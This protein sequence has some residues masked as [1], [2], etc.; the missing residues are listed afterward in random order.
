MKR[1]LF[2]AFI[3]FVFCSTACFNPLHNNDT[4]NDQTTSISDD[5]MLRLMVIEPQN[6]KKDFYKICKHMSQCTA[7]LI[8]KNQK[9]QIPPSL[10]NQ[11][12]ET[13]PILKFK[14][15]DTEQSFYI[16]VVNDNYTTQRGMMMRRAFADK[17]G[18]LF[19]FPE[20]YRHA[21]WMHNTYI[22]LDMVFIRSDGT[23]ANTHKNAEPLN[24]GP[25]YASIG[26]VRFVLELPAGSVQKYE[27]TTSTVFDMTPY[28]NAAANFDTEYEFQL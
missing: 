7:P 22:P 1:Y 18:M 16:E 6:L 17:W 3:A 23:V 9:C 15:D 20:D 12:D 8:C 11:I 14:N 5:Q 2:P 13:T 25:R 21:F 10:I 27:I 19:V 24:D 4:Q 26:E 28:I